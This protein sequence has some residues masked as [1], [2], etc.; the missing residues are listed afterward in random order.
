M[1]VGRKEPL[2]KK[3]RQVEEQEARKG[4]DGNGKSREGKTT[5]KKKGTKR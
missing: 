5:G 3:C 4:R 2:W 1:T